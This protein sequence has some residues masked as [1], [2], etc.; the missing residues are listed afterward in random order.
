MTFFNALKIRIGVLMGEKKKLS[1]ATWIFMGLV[2]GIAV[3]FA[4]IGHAD[5][6]DE[7]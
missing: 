3:G 6:A 2:A 1:M 7:Y 4:F 5:A